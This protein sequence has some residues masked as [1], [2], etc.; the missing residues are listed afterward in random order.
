MDDRAKPERTYDALSL[1]L[2]KRFSK[3]W[4]LRA[5]YTYSRLVG[6]YEGLY[7]SE[8]S[9]YAPNGNNA[10]DTSDL[11]TNSRGY[12]SNDHPHQGKVDGYYSVQAGPGKVTFGLSFVARSGMPRNYISNLIP[13][14]TNQIVFLLPRGS[15]G[16]T[17]A[18]TQL[19]G[20]VSY[21]QKLDKSVTLEAYVDLFNIFDEQATLQTDDNYTFDAV[22]PIANG[23]AQDLKFAK[24]IFG[25]TV[26]K[27][28]N[29]GQPIA[30]QSPFYTRLGLRL[31]F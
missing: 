26:T 6:N 25:Q 20:H 31:M 17:P 3:N 12:L 7:Q 10:Y 8:T 13:G 27:N 1:T 4:L 21:A 30:Y 18:V 22:A 24:N 28:A 14:T 15:A 5:S 2:N 29:F 23:T 16:R 9:Y 19:D 11:Y